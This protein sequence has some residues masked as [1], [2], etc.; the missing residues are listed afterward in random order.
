MV[1]VSSVEHAQHGEPLCAQ[2]VDDYL[3]IFRLGFAR[4]IPIAFDLYKVP[5]NLER[6]TRTDVEI[7]AGIGAIGPVKELKDVRTRDERVGS[8]LD[9]AKVGSVKYREKWRLT[10]N[11]RVSN[12]ATAK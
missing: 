5:G 6:M 11:A 8:G 3:P 1:R 2:V 9:R 4:N 12:S 7:E 10:L